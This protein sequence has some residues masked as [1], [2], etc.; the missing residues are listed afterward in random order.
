M[1]DRFLLRWL[2]SW[3]VRP[4]SRSLIFLF[5]RFSLNIH[6]YLT[7]NHPGL[8]IDPILNRNSV[9]KRRRNFCKGRGRCTAV[10]QSG[11]FSTVRP[12]SRQAI[13]PQNHRTDAITTVHVYQCRPKEANDA[14]QAY[15]TDWRRDRRNEGRYMTYNSIYSMTAEWTFFC[16]NLGG[17]KNGR[18]KA[19]GGMERGWRKG[20]GANQYRRLKL[21]MFSSYELF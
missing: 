19:N 2:I 7:H 17:L 1:T 16:G 10:V 4:L 3:F 14:E 11:P 12:I 5:A 15:D 18:T 9:F 6:C 20:K 21:T 13:H 8:S